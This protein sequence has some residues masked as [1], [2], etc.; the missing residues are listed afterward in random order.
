MTELL[1]LRDAYQRE[2]TARVV[3]VRGDA[4]TLDRTFF[5]PT[6]RLLDIRFAKIFKIGKSTLDADFDLYN[7]FNS[8][9]VLTYTNS[10]SGANGGAWLKPTA[11]IQGRIFKAWVG[12][13]F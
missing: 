8:D 10:Y 3:D 6:V 9:A 2:F 13:D 12:W 11:I 1:Y 4:V 7:A 5:Y